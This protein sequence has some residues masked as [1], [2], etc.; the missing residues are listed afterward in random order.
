[1]DLTENTTTGLV[2]VVIQTIGTLHPGAISLVGDGLY[3][4]L[5]DKLRNPHADLAM[6]YKTGLDKEVYLHVLGTPGANAVINQ[7]VNETQALVAQRS[8]NLKLTRVTI[9]CRGGRHRS[10][11]IAEIAAEHLRAEG[12]AVEV[13]HRHVELPVVQ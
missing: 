3:Y 8:R 10:V 9:A 1:M 11:A 2:Q 12:A 7:I 13:E 5:G 4:D 6:R